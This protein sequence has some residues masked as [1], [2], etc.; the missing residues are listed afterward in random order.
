MKIGR[1]SENALKRS[2]LQQIK[3]KR[4]EVI[5]GA[6]S[7]E[8]C[9]IFAYGDC[10]EVCCMREGSLPVTRLL[11]DCINVM[12]SRGAQPVAV[13]LSVLLPLDAEEGV[14]KGIMAEAEAIC[15]G[16]DVQIAQA[17][18][19]VTSAVNEPFVTVTAQGRAPLGAYHTVREIRPNQ[20]I[21]LSK[22]IGLEGTAILADRHRESLLERYPA[23]LVDA[24]AGFDGYLST[25]PEA[26]V[27]MKSGVCAMQNVSEGGILAALWELAEGAGVGLTVD[28]KRLPIRQETVEICNHC[29]KNPYELLSG[30]CLLMTG[31]DGRELVR[32][33]EEVG[34]PAAMVGRTT[35]GN[36]RLIVNEDEVRY[37]DRPHADGVYE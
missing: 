15:G 29:N 8:D 25:V 19:R 21:V 7:G 16:H 22:W 17:R 32:A 9:A 14:L 34:I 36:D 18:G 27:A 5:S 6:G 11:A 26:A 31:T 28:L 35:D 20:D 12:A 4:E 2:I 37:L 10:A 30:G 3:T 33:L 23:W 13:G 1:V 24:A